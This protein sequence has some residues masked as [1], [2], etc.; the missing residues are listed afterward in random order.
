MPAR[1]RAPRKNPLIPVDDKP[2]AS[3]GVASAPAPMLID[4]PICGQCWP[5]GWASLPEGSDYASCVHGEW[6][7][8]EHFV[9]RAAV[10]LNSAPG[11][12]NGLPPAVI[13]GITTDG[14]PVAI[15]LRGDEPAL[16]SLAVA[17]E[18]KLYMTEVAN[19]PAEMLSV[20]GPASPF[21]PKAVGIDPA[22]LDTGDDVMFMPSGG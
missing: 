21:A 3:S 10:E 19:K 17:S 18:P 22:E 9:K 16:V 7:K 4:S 5:E 8:T 15:E 13:R 11:W 1:Q 20:A 6:S 14:I 2:L 12:P